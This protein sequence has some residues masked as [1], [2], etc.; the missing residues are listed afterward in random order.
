MTGIR[1]EKPESRPEA[2]PEIAPRT[3]PDGHGLDGHIPVGYQVAVQLA[4]YDG[5][6]SWQV[7]GVFIQ[8]GIL[9]VAGAVFPSFAGTH[10]PLLIGWS[11]LAAAAAGVVMTLMF[12]SNI[13]RMRTYEEYWS[14][15]AT[16]LE[17]QMNPLVQTFQG[18]SQLST[19]AGFVAGTVRLRMP[20]IASVKSRQI[21]AA[22][23]LLFLLTF[24][25][26]AALN[27][28]RLLDPS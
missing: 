18:I 17:S 15:H 24:S 13:L 16:H 8:F 20:K 14:L 1:E 21:L 28:W 10:D 12:G 9:L 4:I 7:T 27:V 2:I 19:D 5:T 25:L 23:I 22:I 11:G 6:L 3:P 26:L